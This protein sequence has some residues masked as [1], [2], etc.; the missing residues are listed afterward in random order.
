MTSLAL[1]TVFFRSQACV[2]INY[3]TELDQV[4]GLLHS[5]PRAAISLSYCTG[6]AAN[7]YLGQLFGWGFFWGFITVLVSFLVKKAFCFLH[8]SRA[9]GTHQLPVQQRAPIRTQQKPAFL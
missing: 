3:P 7:S 1:I 2:A 8:A 9:K 4:T 6:L 5:Q